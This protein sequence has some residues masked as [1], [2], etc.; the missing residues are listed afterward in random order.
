MNKSEFVVG[1]SL[2]PGARCLCMCDSFTVELCIFTNIYFMM[3]YVYDKHVLVFI[4]CKVVKPLI[5]TIYTYFI[6]KKNI[7]FN[8]S[9]F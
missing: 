3:H 6:E 5:G 8:S 9:L 2:V 1:T 7:V 4:S